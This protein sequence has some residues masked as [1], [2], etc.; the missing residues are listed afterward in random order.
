MIP[1]RGLQATR[2]S[3]GV[4]STPAKS[5]GI[6]AKIY[7]LCVGRISPTS[8]LVW[9]RHVDNW[10]RGNHFRE[11]EWVFVT[12]PP[13]FLGTL[14]NPL[15]KKRIEDLFLETQPMILDGD[16]RSGYD[17][18]LRQAVGTCYIYMV[19]IYSLIYNNNECNY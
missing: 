18:S 11:G 2:H 17:K 13:K 4:T 1:S 6:L 10:F 5:R 14:G 16:G 9:R 3:C 15:A 8:R 19:F 12:S 7:L